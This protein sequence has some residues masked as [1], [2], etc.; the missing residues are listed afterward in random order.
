VIRSGCFS[1]DQLHYTILGFYSA[2]FRLW[3]PGASML[4]PLAAL[5]FLMGVFLMLKRM[6]DLRFAWPLLVLLS[7]IVG[8]VA[9]DYVPSA[10]RFVHAT[11]A[12][13]LAVALPLAWMNA[14]S[15]WPRVRGRRIL[16]ALSVALLV[17]LL[18]RT[19]L[20]AKYSQGRF[21]DTNWR[22]SRGRSGRRYDPHRRAYRRLAR[23]STHA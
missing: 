14:A 6:R 4:Q 21:G 20:L 16:P 18:H 1:G 15:H 9:T 22:P 11:P 19:S 2:P 10:Q 17:A 5:L 8:S 12:V 7:A 13:A 3:Y 23:L